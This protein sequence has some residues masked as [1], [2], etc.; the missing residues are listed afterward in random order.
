MAERNREAV[1]EIK[2]ALSDPTRVLDALGILGEGRAR[3]RQA[4]GWIIRCPVHGDRTPSCSVQAKDG[5]LV[6]KCHGCDASGDVL[7]LVAVVRGLSLR[8]GFREVLVEA[9]RLASLWHLVDELEGRGARETAPP[10]PAA[11]LPERPA[12]AERPRT[13][14][15]GAEAFWGQCVPVGEDAGVAEHLRGRAI[16]PDAVE[17][18]DLARALPAA[19]DLPAWASYRGSADRA[20]SWR[21]A[22]Y[23]LVVPMRDA[24]GAMR[25]VRGWRVTEG[26]GPKRL[27][28]SGCKA[29]GLVMADGFGIAMLRGE[30]APARVVITEGEPDFLTWA[31]RVRD[32]RTAVIGI[33][34]GSWGEPF[35]ARV[36]LGARVDIR[37]DHDEAGDRYFA[38][39]AKGLK[40]RTPAIYRSTTEAA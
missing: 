9:A 18:R 16:D 31:T 28:P 27:P 8:R 40:R 12:P 6:W 26:E 39:I 38:E 17:G 3:Q 5:A 20:R 32:A 25:A 23:R 19:G 10:R 22:G 2:R 30:R 1:A 36:P 34:S 11:T 21:E 37:V 24:A 13:Y 35:A 15:D 4:S 29:S 7:S 14:P 33:V